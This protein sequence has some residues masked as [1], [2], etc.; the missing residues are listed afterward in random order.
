MVRGRDRSA[1]TERSGRFRGIRP[2]SA[3]PLF[4]HQPKHPPREPGAY[5]VSGITYHNPQRA[6]ELA[7]ARAVLAEL[8]ER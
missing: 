4:S 6:N 8:L 3:L 7:C 5:I 2:I 1:R